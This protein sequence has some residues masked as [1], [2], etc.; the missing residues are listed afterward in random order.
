MLT[1]P[2]TLAL[3][4]GRGHLLHTPNVGRTTVS[5]LEDLLK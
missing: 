3:R 5:C 1:V 4:I 2:T